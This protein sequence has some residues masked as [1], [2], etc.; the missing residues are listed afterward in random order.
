[1]KRMVKELV[2]D[3]FAYHLKIIFIKLP[4]L[5]FEVPFLWDLIEEM[6][7]PSIRVK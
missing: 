3:I 1:M 5:K 6:D 7:T 4:V 2:P